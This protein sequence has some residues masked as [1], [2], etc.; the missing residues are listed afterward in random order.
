MR[1]PNRR[2]AGAPVVCSW[3][4]LPLSM[5]SIHRGIWRLAPIYLSEVEID[6]ARGKEETEKKSLETNRSERPRRT[7]MRRTCKVH[8]KI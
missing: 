4:Y 7:T 5:R 3:L 1:R 2:A 8:E 6:I